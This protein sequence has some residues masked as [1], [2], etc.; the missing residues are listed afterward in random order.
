LATL[1]RGCFKK[2]PLLCPAKHPFYC[3]AER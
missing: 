1:K 2:V 3:L